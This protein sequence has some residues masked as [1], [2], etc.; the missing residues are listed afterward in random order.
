ML[1]ENSEHLGGMPTLSR[2]P[3]IPEPPEQDVGTLGWPEALEHALAC[4]E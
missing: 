2:T 4:I 1:W 3:I